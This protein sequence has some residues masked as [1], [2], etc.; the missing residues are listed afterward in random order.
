MLRAVRNLLVG[1]GAALTPAPAV[2]WADAPSGAPVERGQ[3]LV[4]L[5][6]DSHYYGRPAERL[7]QLRRT[8]ARWFRE[9]VLW[10]WV[11]PGPGGWDWKRY[12]AMFADAADRGLSI[13]PL[14]NSPP[15]WA[16]AGLEAD[17]E[18]FA[19]FT[20][21]FVS[22]YGPSGSF[23]AGRARR[24][25]VKYVE[26]WNEAYIAADDDPDGDERY[27]GLL[28][29]AVDAG[30]RA[31]RAVKYLFSADASRNWMDRLFAVEPQLA[32]WFDGAAVHPYGNDLRTTAQGTRRVGFRFTLDGVRAA[33]DANGARR[34]K[35]WI[36]E[37]GWPTCP[38]G[39]ASDCV[40]ERRQAALVREMASVLRTRYRR[41]V[42]SAFVYHYFDFGPR[43][44]DREHWFG[45]V[46]G[47]GSHKPAFGVF[48]RLATSRT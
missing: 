6:G 47:D 7:D 3:L 9:E 11:Q 30:R 34:A 13:L 21:A 28:K 10:E 27:V 26:I 35:L 24:A 32:R 22:R 15:E 39:A 4:G 48:R 23:W 17:P 14:L 40:S 8:G 29:A 41:S 12:D 1:L 25:P 19:Q 33:L 37:I 2:A 31:D 5:A 46:R 16:G 42:R 38:A 45:L 20:G 18:A 36:T 44:G 43:D